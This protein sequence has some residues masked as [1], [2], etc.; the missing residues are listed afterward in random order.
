MRRIF[1]CLLEFDAAL[2]PQ[3]RAVTR[4]WISAPWGGWPKDLSAVAGCHRPDEHTI[5]R[6][7]SLASSTGGDSLREVVVD[8]PFPGDL[9]LRRQTT[10]QTGREGPSGFA[11]VEVSLRSVDPLLS[12]SLVYENGPPLVVANLVQHVACV[13][14]G[15]K[16]TV[17]AEEVASE[18]AAR[19]GRLVMDPA[20]RLPVLVLV[21]DH[22]FDRA[23]ADATAQHAAG[24]AHVLVVRREAVDAVSAAAGVDI[25][26]GILAQLWWADRRAVLGH[27]HREWFRLPDAAP[28][29]EG[30]PCWPILRK[31]I[32]AA[33]FRIDPPPMTARLRAESTRLR[34]AELEERARSGTFDAELL[35]AYERDLA[36]LEE[37]EELL[38]VAEL[39][40]QRTRED[41]NGLLAAFDQAVASAAPP[42]HEPAAVVAS[43][44]D[45]V[46]Q[47]KASC[48]H[49]VFLDQALDSAER[50]VFRRPDV[51]LR[52]FLTLDSLA[53][54]WQRGELDQPWLVAALAAGVPWKP[55]ISETARQQY[56]EDY[57]RTYDGQ[58]VLLGPHLSW[59]NTNANAVR[60]YLYIDE[61]H[62]TLVIGHVGEHLRDTTKPHR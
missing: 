24:L 29:R 62:R 1:S 38:A 28:S 32:A 27:V 14:A 53:A 45:A 36:R 26:A 57:V 33:A 47:A 56:R 43:L 58:E 39:E 13:D 35:T 34:I 20:G 50:W 19:L 49:L 22:C 16:L 4:S 55:A 52:A 11:H 51:V 9:S 3:A 8:E 31:L 5:V 41:L 17:T 40:A 54:G 30:A 18:S 44:N 25:Q 7:R 46:R 15:R 21:L 12:G 61:H 60:A 23:T 10:I 6:W 59:G 48:Q 37:A 2:E 42:I